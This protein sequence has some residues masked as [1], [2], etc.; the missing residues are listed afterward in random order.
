MRDFILYIYFD[1][2][3]EIPTISFIMFEGC[4]DYYEIMEQLVAEYLL[5]PKGERSWD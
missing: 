1:N 2:D 3:I 4:F 5:Y